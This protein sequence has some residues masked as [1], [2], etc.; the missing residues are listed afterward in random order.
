MDPSLLAMFT[1]VHGELSGSC[2]L[3][4][5]TEDFDVVG[6]RVMKDGNECWS[7][8]KLD[9]LYEYIAHKDGLI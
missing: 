8:S 2:R 1:Y 5:I 4:E 6:L 9:I 3:E 7:K